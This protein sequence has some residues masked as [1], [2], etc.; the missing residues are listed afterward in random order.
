MF[1]LG[2][3][4][5]RP[6]DIHDKFGGNRQSGISACSEH[7]SVFLFHTPKGER[8]GYKDGW[9]S[10]TEYLYSGEGQT[11]DM[12]LVRGNKAIRDHV[13]DSRELHLFEKQEN[14]LYRYAGRLYY[15]SHE[16]RQTKDVSGKPRKVI[17]FHLRKIEN[18]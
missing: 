15:H 10:A 6:S 8:F 2:Q 17:V 11:G 18:R 9:I 4:Y 1:T 12:E 7:P 16:I 5:N 14:G 13:G 3:T